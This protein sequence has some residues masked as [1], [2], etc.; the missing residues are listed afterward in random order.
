MTTDKVELI[1]QMQVVIQ[2]FLY[3]LQIIGGDLP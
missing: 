3:L 1:E 2:F